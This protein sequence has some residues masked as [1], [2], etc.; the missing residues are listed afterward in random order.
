MSVLTKKKDISTLMKNL[1]QIL[2]DQQ[3]TIQSRGTPC[4][5]AD[6]LSISSLPLFSNTHG[7][8]T[9]TEDDLKKSSNEVW[10][11]KDLFFS[12]RISS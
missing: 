4:W 1:Q 10:R 12:Y 6:G 3:L 8:A 2:N 7:N 9:V 5:T 11:D